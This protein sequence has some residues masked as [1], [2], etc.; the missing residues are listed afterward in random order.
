MEND[1]FNGEDKHRLKQGFSIE[2]LSVFEPSTILELFLFYS[3]PKEN[4]NEMVHEL[5]SH[6]S[7]LRG[8]FDA[9]YSE[10]MKIDGVNENAAKL[11]KMI[12][13]I[14]RAYSVDK[15]SDDKIFD[16]ADKLGRYLVDK[17]IGE[18]NEVVY[19]VLLNN[20]FE[21]ITTVRMDEGSV[22]SSQVSPR[23]ILDLIVKY[24]ASMFVMAHNH[25]NGVAIPSAQDMDTTISIMSI[26][27]MIDVKF[28]E[29]FLISENAYVPIIHE[30]FS[31]ER[32]SDENRYLFRN[33]KG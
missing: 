21:I 1:I 15:Y 2:D 24:N 4:T 11:I 26:F 9:D 5:L 12:P 22:N 16:T 31:S 17:Y 33:L 6:F 19:V 8:V 13:Q 20:R 30:T 7:T 27:D 25:P 10:L 18:V 14:C 3:M 32:Q 29:H 28:V 23:K